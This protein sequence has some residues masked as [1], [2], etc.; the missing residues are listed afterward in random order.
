M[1][2]TGKRA[3][4]I[5]HELAKAQQFLCFYCKR[6]FGRKGTPLA[7]TIEH[8]TARM[9][10]GTNAKTNLAAACRHCNQLRGRQMNRARQRR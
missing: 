5:R 4:R 1:S 8:I 7:A 6:R 9:D 3:K 10:G 2:L